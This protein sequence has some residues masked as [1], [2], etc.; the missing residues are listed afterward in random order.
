[1]DT[2][3]L[4]KQLSGEPRPIDDT[5]S[6]FGIVVPDSVFTVPEGWEFVLRQ[7][8][9]GVSYIATVLHNAGCP[10]KIIDTRF[11]NNPVQQV[12]E[13][14]SDVDIVGIA[15]YE[16]SFPFLE[17]LTG[18]IKSAYPEKLIILGGSLV[19]S[20]P[21]VIMENTKADLAV[22]GEGELT[23]LELMEGLNDGKH[24]S[25]PSQSDGSQRPLWSLI[26]P[27]QLNQIEG[28]CYK[29][30]ADKLIFTEPR[31]QMTDLDNLPVMNLSLWPGVQKSPKIKEILISA[32]RGCYMSCSFCY[33]TTPKLS[34]KS[35]AKFRAELQVLKQKHHF[36]FLYL[37]DLTFALP[38]RQR[39]IDLCHVL[40]EF[41][42]R[43]SCMTRVQNLDPE[44]LK[45]M[46]QSGCEIIL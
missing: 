40:K 33:R 44:L 9:E 3:Q 36:E 13:N 1:M 2:Q 17:E 24:R 25:R 37:V 39:T 14:I 45:Q 46:K 32:S 20:V 34:L 43:W 7:P 4:L 38:D 27:D 6:S 41:N 23:I 18:R 15:T 8:F 12:I 5:K 31:A 22:L 10:V 11:S 16:D 26:L 35:P 21:K 42:C 29:T 19:T 28:I 30:P